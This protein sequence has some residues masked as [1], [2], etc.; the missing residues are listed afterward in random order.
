MAER[1]EPREVGAVVAAA[2]GDAVV[3]WVE[4]A[5]V[6]DIDR[7]EAAAGDIELVAFLVLHHCAFAGGEH[8]LVAWDV[9]EVEA[10][11]EAS[12]QVVVAASHR[13]AAALAASHR[14]AAAAVPC[15]ADAS[16][17]RRAAEREV[18]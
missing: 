6:G 4:E 5:R 10:H 14:R 7:E 1:R 13:R 15:P 2:V 3:V 16:S 11:L 18:A 8:A 17:G 9:H 12:A